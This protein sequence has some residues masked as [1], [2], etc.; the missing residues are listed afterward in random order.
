MKTLITLL[1]W[2]A[3][4][5][6]VLAILLFAILLIQDGLPL[7]L[8][9]SDDNLEHIFHV[10]ALLAMLIGLGLGWKWEG[11]SAALV[12]GFFVADLLALSVTTALQVN[13]EFGLLT[14]L[15]MF[16]FP[17]VIVPLGGL[18]YLTC[19]AWKKYTNTTSGA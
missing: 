8:F 14:A 1:R 5:I 10:W 18:F 16:S 19:W 15:S 17:F 12:L 6:S 2:V 3:R 4:I 7:Y 9:T 13:L 11:L